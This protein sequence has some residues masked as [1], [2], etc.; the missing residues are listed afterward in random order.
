MTH[1][2]LTAFQYR[3]FR[4][5]WFGQLFSL[6]GSLMQNATILWHVSLLVPPEQKGLAL[7]LVGLV[8]VLPIIFFSLVSGVAA[9]AL[10]RRKLM[11][12]TQ[13]GMTLTAISL[14]VVTFGGVTNVWPIYLLTA[15]NAAFTS[16]DGPARQA[17]LPNLVPREHLPNAIS[18]YS[19]V[20]HA[21]SVLGPTLG[22]L[23]IAGWGV[24]WVYAFNAISFVAVI[25]GLLAMREVAAK[26]NGD[27]ADFSLS[28]MG[29]G[30]RYVFSAP[31][32]RSSMF[33]DFFAT[34][35]SSATALLPIFVQDILK[36]DETGYGLLY[37][38][39]A[40][41]ALGASLVM[42]R[43]SDQIQRR[44]QVLL[45]SVMVYGLAT[46][47]FG[48]SK[49]FWLTFACLAVSGASDTVSTVIRN[50]IRQLS[51]PDHLRGRMTSVNMIFFM[52][53]PQLGELE[54]GAVASWL[55]APFSVI[56][57]GLGCLLATAIIAWRT[58]ALRNY[59]QH[60]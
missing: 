33:L 49:D 60:D 42:A 28:A 12:L 15:I 56:S 6:A 7:G 27:K 55:G 34:F 9:D 43:V 57:G 52:G 32:I 36:V 54:A 2:S 38:A 30:L 31:L 23:I 45:W 21:A 13:T 5:L 22:G 59:R 53:G 14:A 26:P 24:A 44:G 4:L 46:V 40:L 3:N 17:L 19:I 16:F 39:T 1:P 50:V 20:M 41:G 37:S 58:P 18:L 10:D 47:V 11:L 51:T 48:F 35:F 25:G 8:R 29:D